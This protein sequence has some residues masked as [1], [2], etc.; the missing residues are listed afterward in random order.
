MAA[1]SMRA[2]TKH[3]G[4]GAPRPA[5]DGVTLD[6]ADGETFGLLGPNGAGKTTTVSVCTTRTP[7]SAGTVEVAG[8]D[9]AAAPRRVKR[10]IGVVTQR[11]TLDR[12]I[13]VSQNL[14]YHCRFFAMSRAEAKARTAEMLELF[15][16]SARAR[17]S[18]NELSGGM[19]QRLQIARA[20]S[21]R[22]RVLFLDEPTSGL[23]PQS[24]L[25]LWEAIET[26]KREGTTVFLTTH[27]MEE[28]DQLCDRV[29][30]MDA[31]RV[32]VCG[33]PRELK[34]TSAAGRVITISL[35]SPPNGLA[36]RIERIAGVQAVEPAREGLRIHASAAETP[37][38]R[39]VAEAGA[40]LL[41]LSVSEPSLETVFIAL[42]GRELRD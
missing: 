22:P 6:V 11:C 15:Q 1:I 31:G 37:V 2:L 41:D 8:L 20:I 35:A 4:G 5:V 23:D 14:Y 10:E 40:D 25:S 24:R 26:L 42:T 12:A 21:H 7:P 39:I 38:P 19:I 34:R 32:L 3:Y 33:P 13:T 30:I 27:Y 9:V 16:L 29:A 36:A 28:A 17:G 18:V